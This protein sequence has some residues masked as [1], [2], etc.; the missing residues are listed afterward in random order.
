M[1]ITGEVDE[2]FVTMKIGPVVQSR[3]TTSEARTCRVY[4]SEAKPSFQLT[5]V[6]KFLVYVWA[7]VFLN[8]KK[9][10]SLCLAPRMLLLEVMLIKKFC[11]EPEKALLKD[12]LSQNGQM[13]HP[14]NVLLALLASPDLTERKCAVDIIMKVSKCH[15]I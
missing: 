3:F 2:R 8:A 1:V 12:S 9:Q 10:N 14:E 7:P 6:V 15:Q 4:I 13:A 5:R 11:S